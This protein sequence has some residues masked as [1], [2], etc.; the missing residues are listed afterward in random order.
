LSS[1]AE[2][3]AGEGVARSAAIVG[4]A[5]TAL[6]E[7]E[8]ALFASRRPF[9]FILFARNCE[10]PDQV[11]EL[12]SALRASVGDETAAVLI[13]QEGGRVARLKPPYWPALCAL[14][15]IGDCAAIDPE[16]G[17]EAAWLHARLIA[18]DLLSLGVTVNCAPVLDLGLAGQTEAI[19]DRAFSDDP[20][21]VAALGRAMIEGYMAGGV[22]PV[23]KHMPGHGR[24]LVDSHERLPRVKAR[25]DEL[26]ACDFAPFRACA[27]APLGMTAHILF[28]TLDADAPATQS[29]R[30]IAEVI[31][32]EIGFEGALLSDDLSMRALGGSLFERAARAIQAGCDLALH[33]NGDFDEMVQV[34][35]GAGPLE[36]EALARVLRAFE[37]RRPPE[38]FDAA[39]G[40]ARLDQL[41]EAA[42][43]GA[44]EAC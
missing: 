8:R 14:R 24:A 39:Q 3:R 30:I 19:G 6:L 1:L 11:R 31:R 23:I 21:T 37:T 2:R 13:D 20:A 17:R 34:L 12:T 42:G 29:A 22:L 43:L 44:A 32:G 26:A 36:G 33:C 40:R 4:V 10:R 28:E 5:G 7:S 35:D 41:I 27:D 9:G 18:A 15:R 38:P 25:R 16:A